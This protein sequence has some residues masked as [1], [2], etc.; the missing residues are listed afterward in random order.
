MWSLFLALCIWIKYYINYYFW[1]LRYLA[2]S[3]EVEEKI[4]PSPPIWRI[5]ILRRS[6]SCTWGQSWAWLFAARSLCRIIICS[7][8]FWRLSFSLASFSWKLRCRKNKRWDYWD[9]QFSWAWAALSATAKS[10][11]SFWTC[12]CDKPPFP[13]EIPNRKQNDKTCDKK[14]SR[15]W[16]YYVFFAFSF[17][18]RAT[19]LW[20]YYK[21]TAFN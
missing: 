11:I 12:L 8:S 16:A 4:Q 18:L 13:R 9:L 6:E 1:Q 10:S 14:K 19:I 15:K 7:L 20:I 21:K 2:L 3:W 17:C 5:V